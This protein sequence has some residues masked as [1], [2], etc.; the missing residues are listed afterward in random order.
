MCPSKRK[1]PTCIPK[2]LQETGPEMTEKKGRHKLGERGPCQR[3]FHSCSNIVT[4]L[5]QQ[6]PGKEAK[7]GR[8]RDNDSCERLEA[9]PKGGA[10]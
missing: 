2:S 9:G 3:S 1:V 6:G 10:P 8:L 4:V 5:R 7:R